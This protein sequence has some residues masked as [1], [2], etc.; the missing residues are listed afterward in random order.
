MKG[1]RSKKLEITIEELNILQTEIC[2][3]SACGI[4]GVVC[5]VH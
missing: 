5:G 4:V 1:R 2:S 3:G